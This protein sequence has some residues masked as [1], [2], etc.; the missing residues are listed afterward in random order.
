MTEM[1]DVLANN[2]CVKNAILQAISEALDGREP[3]D[4]MLSFPIVRRVWE[5]YLVVK[6]L[7][8]AND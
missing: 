4:F 7:E 5:I 1:L 2:I 6:M 8:D 3:S